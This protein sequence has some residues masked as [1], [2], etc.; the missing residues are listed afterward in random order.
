MQYSL[1]NTVKNNKKATLLRVAFNFLIKL[2]VV[3]E[4]GKFN[5]FNDLVALVNTH[6][7]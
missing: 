5:G 1:R 2:S 7:A 4:F 6:I 3:D